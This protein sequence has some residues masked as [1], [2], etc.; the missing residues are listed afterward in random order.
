MGWQT[1]SQ[2]AVAA[3]PSDYRVAAQNAADAL[4]PFVDTSYRQPLVDA[5]VL[6]RPVSIP[7]RIHFTRLELPPSED[8]DQRWLAIQCLCTRSTEGYLRQEALRAIVNSTDPAAIPFVALLAGEY[9]VEIIEDIVLA[10]P[11]MDHDSYATFVRENRLLMRRLRA[12][13]TSYRDCYY[14]R[15]FPERGKYPGLTF[16]D[17]IEQWAG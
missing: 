10:L 7:S 12:R 11:T 13:A 3:F 16:L 9:V 6:G 8:H 1:F 4:G 5:Q 17:E 15:R 2:A 14:R